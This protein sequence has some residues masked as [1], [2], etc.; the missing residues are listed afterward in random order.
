MLM[1]LLKSWVLRIIIGVVL[2]ILLLIICYGLLGRY[3]MMKEGDKNVQ[4]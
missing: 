2:L 1:Y 3:Y 4:S